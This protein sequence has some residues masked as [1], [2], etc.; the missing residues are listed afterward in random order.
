MSVCAEEVGVGRGEEEGRLAL[1]LKRAFSRP[2]MM[3]G[4]CETVVEGMRMFGG[5]GCGMLMLNVGGSLA[6]SW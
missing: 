6:S 2:D 1:R 5:V 3:G 4:V